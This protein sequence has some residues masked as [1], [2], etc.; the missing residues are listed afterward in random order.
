MLRK[1]SFLMSL[2]FVGSSF[3]YAN[4]DVAVGDWL[5][6]EKDSIIGVY[7]C[8]DKYCGKIKCL[9]EPNENGAPKKDKENP[10]EK[11]KNR[12]VLGIQI[13]SGFSFDGDSK[14]VDGKIYN[15]RDGKTYCGKMTQEGNTLSLKGNICYTFLGKTNVWTKTDAASSGFTCV[16]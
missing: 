11:L 14:Y 13:M 2:M 10:D 6:P 12:D 15:S 3:I 5:T 1:V 16:K 4:P 9:K 8:G 7:K